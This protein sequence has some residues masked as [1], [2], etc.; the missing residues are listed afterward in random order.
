MDFVHAHQVNFEELLKE[1][2]DVLVAACA[3]DSR[4]SH[5]V[6]LSNFNASKKIA[7]LFKENS[8]LPANAASENIFVEKGFE[9]YKLHSDSPSE[10]M[11]VLDTIFEG[12][13][14]EDVKLLVDYSSMSKVWYGTII[15]YF[16][17]NELD[18]RNLIIYFCY[19]PEFFVPPAARK[20]KLSKPVPVSLNRPSVNE[21]KPLSLIIGLGHDETQ[22]EFLCNFF[23]PD[24][25]YLFIP[26]PSF[27]ENYTEIVKI[28]NKKIISN[29]HYTHVMHYPAK[30]IEEIDSK[31]TSLILNLRLKDRVII[32][33]LGPQTFS[34]ASFLLNA[35]YPDLEIWNLSSVDQAFDL[36]PTGLP[37]VYKAILTNEG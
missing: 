16:A 36:Q 30:D 23:K 5:L 34:L 37:V 31:L 29:V 28:N 12:R 25:I 14:C 35:R 19:T 11:A 13:T 33:S 9:C 27:D 21:N 2:I 32:S 18:Y 20:K 17:F 22:T 10:I 3:N 4:S 7:L 24:D 1:S 26:N 8:N 15:N 6:Q